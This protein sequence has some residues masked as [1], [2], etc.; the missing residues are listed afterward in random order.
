LHRVLNCA[1]YVDMD[2]KTTKSGTAPAN[3]GFTYAIVETALAEVFAIDEAGRR[4]WLRARVQHLRRLGLVPESPGKGR[5]ITYAQSDADRWLIALELAHQGADPNRIV[6]LIKRTWDP[7]SRKH[8]AAEA[9]TRGEAF[10]ADLVEEARAS[11]RIEDDV[12]LTVRFV[13]GM[14]AEPHIGYTMFKGVRSFLFWLAAD[15]NRRAQI[16]DLSKRLR[17]FDAALAK[18]Q[19]PPAPQPKLT[20]L[21]KK[22]V[23]AGRRA[24][25]EPEL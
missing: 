5:T 7:P 16:F 9:V 2:A 23:N 15:L 20:G 1:L 8:S 19:Q 12:F 13:G 21:A 22:I 18:A 4:A 17:E 14:S 6:D 11:R 24:R 3:T 10:I 25:G